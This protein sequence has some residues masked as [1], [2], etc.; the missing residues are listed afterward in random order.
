MDCF[1]SQPAFSLSGPPYLSKVLK[2][3][4]DFDARLGAFAYNSYSGLD[5]FNHSYCLYPDQ[6]LHRLIVVN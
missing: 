4:M 3:I 6:F 2:F 5:G 1:K